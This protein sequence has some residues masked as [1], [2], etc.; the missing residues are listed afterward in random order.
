[1][2][3]IKKQKQDMEEEKIKIGGIDFDDLS[4]SEQ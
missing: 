3:A 2:E 4:S 1:M